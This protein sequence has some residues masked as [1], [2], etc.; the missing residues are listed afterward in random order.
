ME[1]LCRLLWAVG[2]LDRAGHVQYRK[3]F[4]DAITRGTDSNH[5]HYWGNLVDFDQRF[6]EH[7]SL[8]TALLLSPDG[9]FEPLATPVRTRLLS[10]LGRINEHQLPD[11]N[12]HF[13]RV[14]ANAALLKLG[15]EP[16]T[17][18]VDEDLA[19]IDAFYLG[20]GWYSDGETQQRDYYIPMALHYY[21][22]LLSVVAPEILSGRADTY[23][24][25]ATRF[26]QDFQHWFN[27]DGEAV[28]F[29]RSLTYRFAQGAFWGALAFANVEALPWPTIRG[30]WSRHWAW[31]CRRP[32]LDAAD[33]MTVGYGYPNLA[34]AETYNGP[35][36]PGWALK[37]FLPLALPKTHP[38][39]RVDPA[40]PADA[41]RKHEA[42]VTISVQR[43]PRM[44]LRRTPAGGVL[45][46]C[47]G[48]WADFAPRHTP[49]KYAKFA[50]ATGT[51]FNV[52]LGDDLALD[53]MLWLSDDG[54]HWRCRRQTLECDIHDDHIVCRW[55]PFADTE[56]T[57]TL[58][59]IDRETSEGLGVAAYERHHRIH[60]ARP[61]YSR[62]GGFPIDMTTS[63]LIG[64]ALVKPPYLE[65]GSGGVTL[66]D[67][68]R[69]T[70][71]AD[72]DTGRTADAT[73]PIA[74][75]NLL[76]PRVAVP[77]L[78]GSHP[79]G[80]YDLRCHTWCRV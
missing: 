50:Y 53:H 23:I 29:G 75:A 61:L 16:N 10:W 70:G 8:S 41:T 73:K 12:W 25:R 26:A 67:G 4:T 21:G 9:L 51:G 54:V 5:P 35:G 68:S 31:W 56:V 2:P 52:T 58:R 64:P 63:D 57:T 32:I 77:F 49:E 46:L 76:H 79:A 27:D 43:H 6:V 42:P 38:F 30:L 15:G 20:D 7:A 48:Q 66:S 19:R 17:R 62:E 59:F 3:P 36:A 78:A 65:Q 71:I 39:W 24:Q 40:P 72:P 22:L 34:M 45:A 55:Q 60:S 28:P 80:S 33:T 37:F 69:T 13:F 1:G 44:L 11:N 74:N 14:L 18:Q 47:G